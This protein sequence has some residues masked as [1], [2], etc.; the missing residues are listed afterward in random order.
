M[1]GQ[2]TAKRLAVEHCLR[3]NAGDLTGLLSLYAPT[4]RFEDPV[5]SGVRSGLAALRAHATEA[6]AAGVREIPGIPVGAVGGREAAL[7]VVGYLPY[8]PGSPL[9]A[10]VPTPIDTA[11]RVLRMDYVMVV[12]ADRDGR[13]EEM[14][15][16]WDPADI[17]LADPAEVPHAG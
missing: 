12:R 9:A 11:G 15:S 3:V 8:R 1:A 13:I 10:A 2:T 17:V 14:R 7:P 5:G 6:I 4:V 16:Y